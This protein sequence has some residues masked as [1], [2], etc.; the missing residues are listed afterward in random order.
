MKE[1]PRVWKQHPPTCGH[2][3]E[4]MEGSN[5]NGKMKWYPADP[6][7][8]LACDP[9]NDGSNRISVDKSTSNEDE[10][11]NND[12]NE[13]DAS[14]VEVLDGNAGKDGSNESKKCSYHKCGKAYYNDEVWKSIPCA[15]TSCK[16]SIN[17]LCFEYFL[18]VSKL[19][20][21]VK[22]DIMCCA[23]VRCCSKFKVQFTDRSRWDSDDPNGANILP[24]SQ[25]IFLD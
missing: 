20:F 1:V 16:K 23:T 22:A 4:Q 7:L 13:R 2:V 8:C 11:G 3:L 12:D 18:S 6:V 5:V 24:N 25:S 15:N 21:Q 19:Q 14:E 10:D 17:K 9:M